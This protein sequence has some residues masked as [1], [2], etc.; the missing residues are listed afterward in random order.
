MQHKICSLVTAWQQ[1]AGLDH[2]S[3]L[4]KKENMGEA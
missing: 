1:A 3:T 2:E 4:A